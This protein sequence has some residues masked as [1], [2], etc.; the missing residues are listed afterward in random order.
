[1]LASIVGLYMLT[2]DGEMGP[3]VY[4][5]ATKKDQSKLYG[6]NQKEWLENPQL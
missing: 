4:A 6:L 1:M 5:V 2:A 3:E